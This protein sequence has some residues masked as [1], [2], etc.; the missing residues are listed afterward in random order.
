MPKKSQCL[1]SMPPE[2]EDVVL[3]LG[4]RIRAA[5]LKRNW[6]LSDVA[7][8]IGVTPVTL[9]RLEKGDPSV[10]VGIFVTAD[11]VLRLVR[12]FNDFLT[13]ENDEVG[14][15]LEARRSRLRARSATKHRDKLDF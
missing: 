2:L 14:R 1:T 6:T 7:E 11:W 3:E 8:R 9:G 10:G 4:R 13:A 5:R 15:G 12:E